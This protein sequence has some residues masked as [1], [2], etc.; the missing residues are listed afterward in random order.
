[1]HEKIEKKIKKGSASCRGPTSFV[2][3]LVAGFV[4]E[5][6]NLPLLLIT[7]FDLT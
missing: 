2:V 1:M 5:F 4:V 6:P 3:E 7:N